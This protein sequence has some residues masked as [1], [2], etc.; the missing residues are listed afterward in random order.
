[1]NNIQS[2]SISRDISLVTLSNAPS[3]ISFLAFVF[4][5]IA[6][7]GI[8]VDMIGLT[9]PQGDY[10]DISF[11]IPDKDLGTVLEL[12]PSFR[13]KKSDI[14][15]AVSSGN[16]K[17]SVAGEYMRN[18]VGVASRVFA[19][20]SKAGA[21]IRLITTSEVDISML[22]TS[23]TADFALKAIEKEFKVK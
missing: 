3:D 18:T 11:T 12:L 23:Q 6:N 15:T 1:M 5:S 13:S 14:N 9:A 4:D 20:A 8:N 2:I 21:D 10:I 19:A 17:I 7:A 22:M 16:C